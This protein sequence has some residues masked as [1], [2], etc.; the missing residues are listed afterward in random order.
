MRQDSCDDVAFRVGDGTYA[1]VHLTWTSR[2]EPALYPSTQGLG[3]Y[4]TLQT[5]IE[6][7]QH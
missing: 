4:R 1:I 6:A 2:Q 3:G 5:A 7:Q